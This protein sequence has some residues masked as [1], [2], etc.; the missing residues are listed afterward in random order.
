MGSSKLSWVDAIAEMA[1]IRPH[2]PLSHKSSDSRKPHKCRRD[3]FRDTTT[4]QQ[5]TIIASTTSPRVHPM[6]QDQQRLR[7]HSSTTE[8]STDSSN[9]RP[10]SRAIAIKRTRFNSPSGDDSSSSGDNDG[11]QDGSFSDSMYDLA[12]WR[13]FNRII[14]HRQKHPV[15]VDSTSLSRNEKP[16]RDANLSSWDRSSVYDDGPTSIDYALDGEVFDMD[17]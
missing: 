8:S 7:L 9:R 14:D 15:N 4:H 11:L 13:M 5:Q 12:T 1:E 6:Q 17:M 2:I 3:M 10:R 16:A